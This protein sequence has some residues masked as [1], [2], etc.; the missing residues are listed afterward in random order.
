VNT[1]QYKWLEADLKKFDRKATP[2]LIV[3]FHAPFVRW[4]ARGA[5]PRS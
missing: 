5:A 3:Y 2:W 4:A 1:A